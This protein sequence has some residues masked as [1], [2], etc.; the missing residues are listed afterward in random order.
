MKTPAKIES[1]GSSLAFGAYSS[2]FI[3][4]ECSG[5]RCRDVLPT[6]DRL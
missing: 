4:L 3:V 6:L 5:E 2:P 1:H